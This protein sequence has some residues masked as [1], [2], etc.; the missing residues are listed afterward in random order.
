MVDDHSTRAE[1]GERDEDR[2]TNEKTGTIGDVLK[3]LGRITQEDVETALAHQREHG[4]YFGEALVACGIASEDEIEFGL[5]SQFDLPYLFPESDA[6]DLEAASLVSAEWALTHLTLPILKTE[7]TLRVVVDS[8]LKQEP[9]DVLRRRTDL[10]VEIGLA[11]PATVRELIR[12]VYAR[13]TAREEEPQQP[14][15][16]ENVLDTVY[17]ADASRWGIS[18]RGAKAHAWWDE[19]G[20]VR[21]RALAGG[22]RQSLETALRPPPAQM[23]TETRTRWEGELRRGD[24]TQHVS[25]HCIADESGREYLFELRRREVPL[26]ERFPPPAPGIV[27]EIRILARSGTARFAVHADPPELGHEILPHLPELTLDPSWRSVYVNA[28]DQ[29]AASEAF[30]VQ[31]PAD[32]A[33]WEEEME[34]LKIFHFD[35]VTVD[36]AGGHREWAASALDVASVAFILWLDDDLEAAKEAGVRWRLGVTRDDEGSLTWTLES[37]R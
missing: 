12:Q 15:S 32:P 18:V 16:L 28:R 34:A 10:K 2:M 6:V 17:D 26:E 9:I 27:S 30:S 3:G 37:L 1:P 21:R 4:G 23:V 5:A 22:W 35:V 11:A 14:L 29:P 19:P 31:L 20:R 36:L 24:E 25:I 13:A 33:T 8:P 7:D